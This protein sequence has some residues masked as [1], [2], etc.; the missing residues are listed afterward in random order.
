MNVIH[1]GDALNKNVLAGLP[2]C[3]NRRVF[4]VFAD[5]YSPGRQAAAAQLSPGNS[6]QT[7]SAQCS[8]DGSTWTHLQPRI[9]Q[10][11]LLLLFKV[12]VHGF[13]Q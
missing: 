3:L 6:S 13:R 7:C 4:R 9:V 10:H 8:S 2:S 11:E 1:V 5:I 12:G